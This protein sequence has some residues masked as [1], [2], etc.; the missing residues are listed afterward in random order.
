MSKERK[1]LERR[2]L[3]DWLKVNRNWEKMDGFIVFGMSESEE[4]KRIYSINDINIPT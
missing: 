1:L 2:V 3:K 4:K